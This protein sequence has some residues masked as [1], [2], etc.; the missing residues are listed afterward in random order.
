MRGILFNLSDFRMADTPSV[1][2]FAGRNSPVDRE[3][4]KGIEVGRHAS[5]VFFLHTYN[6]QRNAQRFDEKLARAKRGKGEKL[7]E[8]EYPVVLE[9][10]IHYR[11]GESATVPVRYRK[12]IGPW[13]AKGQVED[14]VEAVVAWEAAA[15]GVEDGR[16][17]VY[18]MQWNN[19]KPEKAIELIDIRLP[20]GT[21]G[22]EQ[23][24]SPAVFAITTAGTE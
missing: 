20:A 12:A 8:L 19:P 14:M 16:L 21:R 15:K 23:Y 1:A 22:I 6:P 18:A 7:L 11:G 9:Y 13:Y 2:A 24:G 3:A 10:V 17:A 4:Y 5:A